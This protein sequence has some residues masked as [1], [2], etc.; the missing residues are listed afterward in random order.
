M[1]IISLTSE[2]IATLR[3]LIIK[4]NFVQQTQNGFWTNF[5]FWELRVRPRR[6]RAQR[7]R[8]RWSEKE[9]LRDRDVIAQSSYEYKKVQENKNAK[10]FFF[11]LSCLSSSSAF[12]FSWS[13]S[14]T[15]SFSRSHFFFFVFSRLTH[16]SQPSF[17]LSHSP[18]TVSKSA[19]SVPVSQSSFRSDIRFEM[20]WNY[21]PMTNFSLYVS[22][23]RDKSGSIRLN[24]EKSGFVMSPAR[25]PA[26]GS[27]PFRP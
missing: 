22:P 2:L 23:V 3:W 21:I 9:R 4:L 6:L 17:F 12:P 20:V 14:W 27:A 10:Q 25:S 26:L 15:L 1:L 16:L 7:E 11:L 5:E 8:E 24:P 19:T 13:S 18:Q